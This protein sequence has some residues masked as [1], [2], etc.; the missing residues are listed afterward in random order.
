MAVGVIVLSSI[1]ALLG[2]LPG[3]S[4]HRTSQKVG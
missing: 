3:I 4:R 2:I 1:A